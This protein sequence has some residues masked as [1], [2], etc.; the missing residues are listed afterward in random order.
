E[1]C[2][3]TFERAGYRRFGGIEYLRDFS[4]MEPEHLAQNVDGPLAWRQ[5]L[6]LSDERERDRFGCLIL[7]L[8]PRCSIGDAIDERIRI[9]F[10]PQHLPK[11]SWLR[12]FSWLHQRFLSGADTTRAQHVQAA[13]GGHAIQPRPYGG[14][15]LE[16]T[17]A[18]PRR[19]QCLLE[20]IF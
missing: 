20:G 14:P 12:Q 10:D 5:Q 3:C 6:Q 2:A 15:A 16:R 13:A 7:R 1:R 4:S 8:W 17:Q 11:T 18:T 9:R 19:D